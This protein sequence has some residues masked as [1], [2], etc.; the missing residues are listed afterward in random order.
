MDDNSQACPGTGLLSLSRT[1]ERSGQDI[2]QS[3]YEI[4]ENC[5]PTDHAAQTTSRK[6][7][8]QVLGRRSPSNILDLGCGAGDSVDYFRSLAPDSSWTG[9]D[10]DMSPE[11]AKRER[12]EA[13][14]VTFDGVNIP[15][16]DA[17][18]D[19]V[20]SNQVLEHV[21]HPEQLLAQVTRVLTDDGLFVG[22]TSQLEPYHSFSLWNYTIYGFKRLVEDVGMQLVELRPGIDGPTLIERSYRRRPPEMSQ[23]FNNESPLNQKIEARATA[24]GRSVRVKNYR[25]L[26]YCGH[27]TFI[28]EVGGPEGEHV[29]ADD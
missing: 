5:I 7:V 27:F 12:T 14:F 6:V 28:C 2:M 16:P 17:T 20:Y 19:L 25:K 18:F 4:L 9:I 23:Y 24:S 3:I 11:V 21:R 10:I 8:E 22:S 29:A 1:E 15:F 13:E 26:L